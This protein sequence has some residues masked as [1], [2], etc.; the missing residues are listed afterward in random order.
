MFSVLQP[1]CSVILMRRDDAQRLTE[2]LTGKR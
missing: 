1:L 2:L